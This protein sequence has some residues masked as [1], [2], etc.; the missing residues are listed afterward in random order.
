MF[1]YKVITVENPKDL[2]TEINAVAVDG[3]KVISI[4][5]WHNFKAYVIVTFEREKK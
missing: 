4:K 1:E 2:E 3:W 5:V